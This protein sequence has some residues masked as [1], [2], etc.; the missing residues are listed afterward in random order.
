MKLGR[1]V[2]ATLAI[3][4]IGLGF[5]AWRVDGAPTHDSVPTESATVVAEPTGPSGKPSPSPEVAPPDLAWGPSQADWDAALADARALRLRDAA[6]QVIMAD[7]SHP[8][9]RA[10]AR[11]VNSRHLAG[12]LIMGGAVKSAKQVA[13]LNDAISNASK[14]CITRVPKA[15]S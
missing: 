3:V 13:A 12:V 8:G 1:S 9:A 14:G 10:A 11:L 7:I 4:A 6:G 2:E 15:F 5:V